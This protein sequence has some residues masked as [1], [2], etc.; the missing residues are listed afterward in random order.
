MEN[1]AEV[2]DKLQGDHCDLVLMDV[3]MPEIDGLEAT[4]G[5]VRLDFRGG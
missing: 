1:G 2:I 5:I 3:E 4:C